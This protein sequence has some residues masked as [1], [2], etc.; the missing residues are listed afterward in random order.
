MSSIDVV[1]SCK[2]FP[3]HAYQNATCAVT[4]SGEKTCRCQPPA[5]AVNEECLLPE[6]CPRY[7]GKYC[8][9]ASCPLGQLCLSRDTWSP[10]DYHCVCPAGQCFQN[11]TCIPQ[12]DYAWWLDPRGSDLPKGAQRRRPR[13]ARRGSSSR[14][15]RLGS[16][17]AKGASVL[18]GFVAVTVVAGAAL[19]AKWLLS[20]PK[21]EGHFQCLS[22]SNVV[23]SCKWFHCDT[24]KNATCATN[25]AGLQTC[26][27][28][29][30]ACNVQGECRLP[31]QCPRSARH[32]CG[33]PWSSCQEG[34]L[35]LSG[36]SWSPF[37]FHCVCPAGQCMQNATCIAE[38]D[39]NWSVGPWG[40]DLPEWKSEEGPDAEL[41]T[42]FAAVAVAGLALLWIGA[43]PLNLGLK[44]SSRLLARFLS[45]R[46]LSQGRK[47]G[48]GHVAADSEAS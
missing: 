39:Y 36:T 28:E 3:C 35:C 6:Q 41:F 42:S 15:R 17:A 44:S 29:P 33:W 23:G 26:E 21:P 12:E 22:Q 43:R 48:L 1:G 45:C 32:Y 13:G 31:G 40:I 30:P 34:Q 24:Y 38:K 10:L 27:C 11:G 9:L 46:L 16:T 47:P 14:R 19:L 37:D 8:G 20:T 7:T 4:R 18:S 5:C 2:F 25:S